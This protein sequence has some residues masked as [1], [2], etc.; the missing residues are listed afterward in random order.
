[1]GCNHKPGS[2]NAKARQQDQVEFGQTDWTSQEDFGRDYWDNGILAEHEAEYGVGSFD[3]M[4]EMDFKPCV[5]LPMTLNYEE[6]EMPDTKTTETKPAKAKAEKKELPGKAPNEVPPP[7]SAK[8]KA[9]PGGKCRCGCGK[10]VGRTSTF[11]QGHDAK[12]V[13]KLIEKITAGELTEAAAIKETGEVSEALCG[14]LQKA[15][16]NAATAKDKAA[17]AA[18]AKADKAAE[19]VRIKAEAKAKVDAA[20]IAKAEAE[21]AKPASET[22]KDVPD[23]DDDEDTEDDDLD[24]EDESDEDDDF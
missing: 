18:K 24:L 16:E 2:G 5:T 20:K 22:S 19:V 9:L 21:K 12:F 6:I 3:V 23:E 15:I 11:A 17:A 7:R 4:A 1:V 13:S 14:K 10:A 8:S